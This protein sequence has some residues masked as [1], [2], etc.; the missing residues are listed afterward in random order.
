LLDDQDSY[1]I[2]KVLGSKSQIFKDL[3]SPGIRPWFWKILKSYI[4]CPGKQMALDRNA[5]VFQ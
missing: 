1:R 4:E 2:W 3:E 5:E